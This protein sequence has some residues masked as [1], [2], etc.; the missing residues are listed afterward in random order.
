MCGRYGRNS[1][2]QTIAEAF[3]VKEDSGMASLIL[4]PNDDIRPTTFQ[5]IV[6][7]NEDGEPAIELARWGFVLN[8]LRG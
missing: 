1:D 4:A 3:R 7:A 6:R 5:P 2:K 8:P